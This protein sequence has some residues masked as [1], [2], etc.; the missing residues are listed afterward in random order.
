MIGLV[1]RVLWGAIGIL[2]LEVD[3]ARAAGMP[4]LDSATFVPQLVWL[5]ISFS[6]LYVVVAKIALPR[7]GWVLE[8]RRIRIDEDLKRADHLKKDAQRVTEVYQI[9]VLEAREKA[10]KILRAV[11]QETSIKISD[12]LGKLTEKIADDMK[13]AEKQIAKAQDRAI[14]NFKTDSVEVAQTVIERLIEETVKIPVI[15]KTVEI[16][17]RERQ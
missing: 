6:I 5:I 16:V 14:E 11:N 2:L 12:E 10:Q 17:L 1:K 15:E 4:Q 13:E 7:I 9:S 3:P 8:E